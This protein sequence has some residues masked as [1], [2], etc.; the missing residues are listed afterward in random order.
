VHLWD[1]PEEVKSWLADP[2]ISRAA[3][4]ARAA[5]AVAYGAE[6]PRRL[7]ARAAA[8]AAWG[9]EAAEAA[10]AAARAAWA[11]S[12][13]A[14]A[15]RAVEHAAQALGTTIGQLRL[16]YVATWNN[17][18]LARAWGEWIEA[19]TVEIFERTAEAT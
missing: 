18:E 7:A 8:R 12:A 2:K 1:A 6:V 3:E 4:A 19:A 17:D 9:A 15:A 14:A 13:A 10:A 16:D 5:W 11:A